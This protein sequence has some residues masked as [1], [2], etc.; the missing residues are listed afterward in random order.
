MTTRSIIVGWVPRLWRALVAQDEKPDINASVLCLTP[1]GRW[2]AG[3]LCIFSSIMLVPAWG[4][5]QD[6]GA[7]FDSAAALYGRG[8]FARA[9]EQYE[10]LLRQGYNDARIWYNLGNAQFKAGHLGR[11][12]KAYLR[13]RR[14]SPRD[15]DILAN[16]DFIRLYAVDKLEKS[17]RLFLLAWADRLSVRYTL[18]EW[19]AAAGLLFLVLVVLTAARVWFGWGGRTVWSWL[20]F[21]LLIWL[22]T[23]GG[24]IRNYR[25]EYVRQRAVVVVAETDIRGGPGEEYT[26][27][28]AGHDGLLCTVDRREGGWYLVT[29]EN[30]VKGW[31]KADALERI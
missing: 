30:G 31:L 16:L 17:G 11:A 1:L 19:L 4:V 20:S 8:E 13:A 27:Q 25:D 12:G 9:A 22:L 7:V 15:P 3:I 5:A 18:G 23:I 24:A 14:L 6:A 28:F 21:G 10:L 2:M 26:L 29:F